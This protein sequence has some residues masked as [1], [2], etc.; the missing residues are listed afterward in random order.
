[1][2]RLAASLVAGA[3]FTALVALASPQASAAPPDHSAAAEHR[4]VTEY[5]TQARRDA[6]VPRDVH[7]N[8]RPPGG[9]GGGGGGGGTVTG[10]AWTGGGDV[11][12]TTGK[13]FFT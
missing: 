5:W 13:V 6:A 1:M 9:G 7:L 8:R 2:H 3:V 10:A 12:L 11:V 4:R